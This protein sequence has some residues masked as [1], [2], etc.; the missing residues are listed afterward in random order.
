MSIGWDDDF[1][2]LPDT[3]SDERSHEDESNDERLKEERPPHWE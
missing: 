1:D 3:T 2:I